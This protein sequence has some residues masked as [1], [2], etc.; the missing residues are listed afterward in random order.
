MLYTSAPKSFINVL[1]SDCTK[2]SCRPSVPRRY[3]CCPA[4]VARARLVFLDL[5][6]QVIQFRRILRALGR[7][8]QI[9]LLYLSIHGL[10]LCFELTDS[11]V[12][13]RRKRGEADD[14]DRNRNSEFPARATN[15]CGQ[16][17]L[18]DLARL[19]RDASPVRPPHFHHGVGDERILFVPDRFGAGPG[20][21]WR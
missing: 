2:A 13:R 12:A 10:L 5:H 7:Q 1:I 16:H 9:D 15:R 11:P 20:R 17:L 6:G 8:Q 14:Q 19:I 21:G 4:T 3:R 18:E